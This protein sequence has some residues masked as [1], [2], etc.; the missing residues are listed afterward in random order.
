MAKLTKKI[1]A[2]VYKFAQTFNSDLSKNTSYDE[3]WEIMSDAGNLWFSV[4][5]CSSQ[6]IIKIELGKDEDVIITTFEHPYKEIYKSNAYYSDDFDW[7]IIY[8]EVVEYVINNKILKKPRKK[9]TVK[10]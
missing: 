2:N 10:K 1:S 8:K 5:T 9:R 7:N 6:K 4:Y 3:A